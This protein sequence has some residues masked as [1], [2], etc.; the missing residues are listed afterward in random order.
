MINKIKYNVL[1]CDD[2]VHYIRRLQDEICAINSNNIDYQLQVDA[3]TTSEICNKHLQQKVYDIVILDICKNNSQNIQTNA[4]LIRNSLNAEYYGS[5][6]YPEVRKYCP[7]AKIFVVSNLDIKTSKSIFNGADVEYF[8]K[9]HTTEIDIARHIKNFFDTDKSRIFNNVFVVYG[10]NV[11]MKNS[12]NNYILKLGLRSVD[13]F[14]NSSGG[15][16]SI[17][18]ALIDCANA[19]ECAIVLLSADDVAI[20]EENNQR[21]YRARQN[22][23]FEMGFFAGV[24]GKNKVIVLYEKHEHFEFPSDIN[25]VYYIEYNKGSK[26]KRELYENLQKIGFD[27]SAS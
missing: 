10:H 19:I 23:I 8:C 21:Y 5:E 27:I 6:L 17:F 12:V 24:L 25:G 13:L 2:N 18:D 14:E 7:E 15:I 26:W 22:V 20:D 3:C 1:I 9:K 4:D 11:Q 16:Q